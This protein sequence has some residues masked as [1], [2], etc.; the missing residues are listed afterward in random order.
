MYISIFLNFHQ[1][2][3]LIIDTL[4]LWQTIIVI[5]KLLKSIYYI[6]LSSFYFCIYLVD[7][8]LPISLIITQYEKRDITFN[9]TIHWNSSSRVDAYQYFVVNINSVNSPTPEVQTLSEPSDFFTLKNNT[10][11]MLLIFHFVIKHQI[12]TSVCVTNNYLSN[13]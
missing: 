5:M 7:N 6:N 3:E 2:I 9:F 1:S 13:G 4:I 12:F 8:Y 10:E 11:Y